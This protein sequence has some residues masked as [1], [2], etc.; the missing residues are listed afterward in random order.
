MRLIFTGGRLVLSIGG[1]ASKS[2]GRHVYIRFS[3]QK[4]RMQFCNLI[5][6]KA[7]WLELHLKGWRASLSRDGLELKLQIRLVDI[8][9]APFLAFVVSGDN[10][11]PGTGP[12]GGASTTMC[13]LRKR[14]LLPLEYPKALTVRVV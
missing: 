10:D 7:E 2:E 14:V 12:L 9:N 6:S 8:R 5:F 11:R 4:N 3:N 1:F 13:S